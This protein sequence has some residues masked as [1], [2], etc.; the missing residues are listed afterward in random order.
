M[1]TAKSIHIGLN[2]VDPNGYNGWDGELSGCINDA[3]DMK[4]IADSL[5]YSSTLLTDSDA[6]SCRL[7]S[8]LGQAAQDL[9]SGDILFLSYSGHG[10]QVDDVNGDEDD[11]LDETWCL[12]D[13][14][15]IDDE[16]YSLW[17]QFSPGVR[18][19]VLSD[20]CH[21]GT[22]LRM[23]QTASDLTVQMRRT[24]AIPTPEQ[25]AA[26]DA[27]TKGLGIDAKEFSNAAA[28][29]ERKAAV[30]PGFRSRG[31]PPAIA[32]AN[33][34][35]VPK[36][37]PTDVQALVNEKHRDV[38]AAAQWIAGP[39][40]RAEVS[41]TVILISGCQDNQLSMDGSG[42][43]LFTEKLKQVWNDGA[44]TG[45]YKAFCD[46]I[47]KLMPAKQQPNF[48]EVGAKNPTF[49]GQTPFEIGDGAA[50]PAQPTDGG[51]TQPAQPADTG[52]PQPA[53]TPQP[54]ESSAHPKLQ[55][56]DSGDAVKELKRIL[57][58]TGYYNGDIDGDFDSVTT[59]AVR[60]FQQAYGLEVTGVVDDDT[61]KN[62]D[63]AEQEHQHEL[64]PA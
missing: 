33:L 22:V 32:S 47:K 59:S 4:A 18:I 63:D 38:Y 37:M 15:F 1:P 49:E 16:L 58:D 53:D 48:Y 17:E 19:I 42:N 35:G 55:E 50:A 30:A 57:A 43:G 40:E 20:S 45:N 51:T 28:L 36:R 39:S 11:A 62:L 6:T 44:F 3:T 56:G 7:T 23:M 64:E 14:Q 52:Q 13:R 26:L 25:K 10:G 34:L 31:G 2:H 61:W 41:A 60:S 8:E 27:I 29:R 9:Q 5:G 46:A 12:Y 24:R 21:S 54:T